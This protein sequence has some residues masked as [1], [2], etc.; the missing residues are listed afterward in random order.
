MYV[1]WAP[2][3]GDEDAC[4]VSAP[5]GP[6]RIPA[7][8]EKSPHPRPQVCKYGDRLDEVHRAGAGNEQKAQRSP[9]YWKRVGRRRK[10]LRGAQI[11]GVGRLG[12]ERLGGQYPAASSLGFC[13]PLWAAESL[14][15]R[16]VFGD[17]E[18]EGRSPQPSISSLLHRTPSICWALLL[19]GH[20]PL[21]GQRN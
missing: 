14:G 9:A 16:E 18:T 8:Q 1:G 21:Q 6:F 7:A 12:G 2:A 5:R 10:P 13:R 3:L 11:W 15:T 17:R 20:D 4:W 19:Q